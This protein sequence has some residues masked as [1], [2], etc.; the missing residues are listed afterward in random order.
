L[1]DAAALTAGLDLVISPATAV[2]A[3]AGALGIPVWELAS[4]DDWTTLGTTGSP[5][6][7]SMRIFPRQWNEQWDPVI[8]AAA[9]QLRQQFS[10]A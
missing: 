9:Q 4:A 7:P 3:T 1:D 5:W 6:Y 8:E 2:A 10:G